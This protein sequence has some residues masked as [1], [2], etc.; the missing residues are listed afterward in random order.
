MLIELRKLRKLFGGLKAMDEVS[1]SI[2]PG[3]IVAVLGPNGA[4]KTTLLRA[5]AGIVAPDTGE[6]LYDN[7]RFDRGR[8]ELRRKFVFLPDF[9]YAF[10]HMDVLRHMSMMLRLYGASADGVEERAVDILRNLDL[11]PLAETPLANLSRGQLYKATLAGL[12]I[13]NPELWLLDEPFASGMDAHGIGYLK[14]QARA[15]AARGATVLYSTQILDIA[16]HFSDRVCVIHKG[17]IELFA[18]V[19]EMTSIAAK[20]AVLETLFKQLRERDG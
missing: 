18:N 17:K 9:P 2:A 11:L 10:G 1:L 20:G 13:V 4:G 3:Q 19:D 12:L 16:E 6:I 15:A 7:Q 5:L 8:M 14:E